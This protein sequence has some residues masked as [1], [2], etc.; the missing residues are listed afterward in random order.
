MSSGKRIVVGVSGAS[1]AAYAARTVQ[2]LL[3]AG[4]ETH[5]VVSPLGQ[6]LLRDELGMEAL[7]L[8]AGDG[9]EERRR[10]RGWLGYGWRWVWVGWVWVG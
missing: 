1:G 10:R 3:M 7:D 9:C 4:V 6:R 5:L 2:L 8:A